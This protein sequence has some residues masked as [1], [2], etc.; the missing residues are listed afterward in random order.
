[1]N[2]PESRNMNVQLLACLVEDDID[3]D[4]ND[5]DGSIYRFLVDGK[6]IKYVTTA[7]GTF[8]RDL[9]EQTFGP[10]L[11]G[12]LLPPFPVGNWNNGYVAKDPATGEV[13]FIK[14]E[15]VSLPRVKNLWHPVKLNEL[16]F[17][18]LERLRQRVRIS[19]HPELNDGKPVLIKTAIW[20]WEIASMETETTIYAHICDRDIGPRFLGH[21]T[22]G[23]DGRVVGFAVEWVQDA[24]TAGPEDLEGCRKALGRL[25]ELGIKLSDTNKHNFLVREGNNVVLVDFELAKMCSPQEL[26]DEMNALKE[27]LEDTSPRGGPA[28]EEDDASM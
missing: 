7:P 4:T 5:P 25:H 8:A 11:L 3:E 12:E 17:T 2:V 26:E 28:V 10:I 19:T 14:T 1:M 6:Y 15:T 20:H 27:C 23:V 13:A 21:V 24:R 16:D 22:E 18:P 9:F